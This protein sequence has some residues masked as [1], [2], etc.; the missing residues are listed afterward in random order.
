MAT[1]LAYLAIPLALVHFVRRRRD[2]VYKPVFWLFAA[3]ILLCGTTHWLDLLTIWV[4]AYPVEALLKVATALVSVATAAALW[5][6]MPHLLALPSPAQVQAANEALRESEAGFRLL[7]EHASD[8]VSRVGPDG[9]RHY[10]SPASARVLGLPPEALIGR[11][12]LDLV[13]SEDR[14]ALEASTNRLL[15]GAVDE[16]AVTFRVF[17]PDGKEVW[18][19]GTARLLRH[20][21]TGAPDGYIAVSR[22]VTEREAANLALRRLTGELEARVR[23]EVAAREAAQARAAHGERMQALGQLAGGVAHDFNN[24]LQTVHGAATL[25][26]EQPDDA[27]DVQNLARMVLEAADR[28]ASITRRLLAFARRADLRAEVVDVRGLLK[29]LRDILTH[30]LGATI[31][32]RVEPAA[33]G[34]PPLLADKGQLE[35]AM[36]NLATNA[37][38][39]MP[40]GG[41]LTLAA[42]AE[43]VPEQ[44]SH[45]AGLKPGR[46]L[47]LSVVDS[48]TGMDAAILARITEPF[49]TTKPQGQGT[50]LGLSMAKGFAE[51]SGGALAIDS[52][53]GR[54]TTVTLWLPQAT[55]AGT[56]PD[57]GRTPEKLDTVPGGQAQKTVSPRVLL[58]DDEALVR[59]VLAVQLQRAG[60]V[61]LATDGAAAALKLLDAGEG[62][63]V[64]VSDLTMPG[65]NGVVLIREAQARHPDLPAVLLTGY[66]D[67][68]ATFAMSEAVS[69]TFSLL[70]KPVT[71]NQLTSRVAALLTTRAEMITRVQTTVP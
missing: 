48:G 29:G 40:G 49:F 63:D 18:I 36:V 27:E 32:V 56:V 42:V 17:R 15:A 9:I 46:Y 25:I 30:T 28:G 35:T 47:R 38:D 39:A 26:D 19:E 53:L 11:S 37:R 12:L 21:V 1:G 55:A 58:V 68:G 52:A 70:R 10:V 54:G 7:A 64:I 66:A 51:Q 31:I 59:K 2:L 45:P 6:L 3:F 61:V 69:G 4:P 60:Y 23:E 33:Y 8:V 71:A 41:V 16:D 20:P 67:D 24:M 43:T 22:D 50:G 44:R 62:V 57:P 14:P 65:M 34:L 5:P 13:R